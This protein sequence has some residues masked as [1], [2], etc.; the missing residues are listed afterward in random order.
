MKKKVLVIGMALIMLFSVLAFVGASCEPSTN[1]PYAELNAHRANAI[2][3]LGDFVDA[4]DVDD[5]TLANWERIEEYLEVGVKAINTAADKAGVDYALAEA[6]GRIDIVDTIAYAELNE[7]K[8]NAVV[9][10][11]DYVDVLDADDFT[12]VNW[13]RIEGYFEAGIK[14]INAATAKR[15]VDFALAE[16]KGRINSVELWDDMGREWGFSECGRFALSIVVKEP[17]LPQG[18]DFI[19][20]V[21]LRNLSGEDI[22]IAIDGSVGPLIW[23]RIDGWNISIST[24]S[25]LIFFKN[26]YPIINWN[27]RGSLEDPWRLGNTLEIG[28]HELFFTA[29]FAFEWS[30]RNDHIWHNHYSLILFASNVV[31]LNVE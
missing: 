15:Y 19:I 6:K 24:D 29:A 2:V 31:A 10:L 16:A 13:G 5:F 7:H 30:V 4:L 22:Y 14:A 17:T 26:D 18:Q 1:D 23:P 20:D 25:R 12:V 28:T 9:K 21:K 3:K 27:F 8:A 11:N